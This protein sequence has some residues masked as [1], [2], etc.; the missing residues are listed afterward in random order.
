MENGRKQTTKCSRSWLLI[1]APAQNNHV[2]SNIFVGHISWLSDRHQIFL[3]EFHL[4][5]FPVNTFKIVQAMVQ[6]LASLWGKR[7]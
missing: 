5:F 7:L 3:H 6:M 4:V 2:I 1:F